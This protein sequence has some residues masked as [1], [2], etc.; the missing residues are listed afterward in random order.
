MKK[1]IILLLT[2]TLIFGVFVSCNKRYLYIDDETEDISVSD[3]PAETT[4]EVNE[5][6]S[7]STTDI[8]QDTLNITSDTLE[9]AETQYPSYVESYTIEKIDGQYYMVFN[10]Y[11]IDPAYNANDGFY[12]GLGGVEFLTPD[13][14]FIGLFNN[15]LD[16][17]TM[18]YIVK[19]F[20]RTENGIPIFAP[21][22]FYV[23]HMPQPWTV[24][25]SHDSIRVLWIN[26]QDYVI[27]GV[28]QDDGELLSVRVLTKET[29]D[30]ELEDMN[31]KI[32][33]MADSRIIE[34]GQKKVT[35]FLELTSTGGGVH[36]YVEEG[37][38]YYIY[39]IGGTTEMPDDEYLLSFGLRKYNG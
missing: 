24:N 5:S 33:S 34:N 10:S 35:A 21:D 4:S 9:W 1:L 29:F 31:S 12:Y 22:N 7:P 19:H 15:T 30:Y 26:G 6:T 39:L 17:Y 20:D 27:G 28:N 11:D 16:I 36:L 25:Q 14:L 23:P 37:D 18:N 38:L 32:N 3:E 13:E 2:L 8:Y